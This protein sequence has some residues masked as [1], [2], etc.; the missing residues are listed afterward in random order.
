[1]LQFLLD[2]GDIS[3]LNSNIIQC[4]EWLW[5]THSTSSHLEKSLKN[6]EVLDAMFDGHQTFIKQLFF[7]SNNI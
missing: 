3:F 7:L 4:I 5:Q 2:S 1:M 6:I